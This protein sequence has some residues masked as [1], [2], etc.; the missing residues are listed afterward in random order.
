M[1]MLDVAQRLPAGACAVFSLFLSHLTCV[2]AMFKILVS[3]DIT[4]IWIDGSYTGTCIR[5]TG[6]NGGERGER[7]KRCTRVLWCCGR[8]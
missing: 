6:A 3:R 5:A 4:N 7:D 1:F 2:S 8:A